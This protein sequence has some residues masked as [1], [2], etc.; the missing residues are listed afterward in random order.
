MLPEIKTW[1]YDILNAIHEIE[2][3]STENFNQY[4]QDIKTRRASKEML[5]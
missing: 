5:K 2:G 1:L 4:Q 3:F